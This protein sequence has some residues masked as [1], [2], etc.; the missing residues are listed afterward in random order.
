MEPHCGERRP[1]RRTVRNDLLLIRA[2]EGRRGQRENRTH[3]LEEKEDEENEDENEE[4]EVEKEEKEEESNTFGRSSFVDLI[5][6]SDIRCGAAA[7]HETRNGS[8]APSAEIIEA[9]ERAVRTF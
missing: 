8:T 3:R 6:A 1:T 7:V 9:S 2:H 4:E 5:I